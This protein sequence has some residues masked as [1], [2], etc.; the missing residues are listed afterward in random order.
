MGLL[1]SIGGCP[2]KTIGDLVGVPQ[3]WSIILAEPLTAERK[4]EGGFERS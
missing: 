1:R 3:N 2:H 4:P